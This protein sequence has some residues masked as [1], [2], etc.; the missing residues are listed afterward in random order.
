[1][2]KTTLFY[3]LLQ[4]IMFIRV[5]IGTSSNW[6]TCW[7]WYEL[8]SITDEYHNILIHDDLSRYINY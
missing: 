7:E 2:K 4:I 5:C 8:T 3:C 6:Y 1:M